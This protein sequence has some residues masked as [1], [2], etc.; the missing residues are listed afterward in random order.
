MEAEKGL[1]LSQPR[2]GKDGW[3]PPDAGRKH[4]AVSSSNPLKETNKSN[5]L[6]LDF[7][8]PEL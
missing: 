8:P 4:G 6:V 1:M 5:T 7:W 3:K 2:N